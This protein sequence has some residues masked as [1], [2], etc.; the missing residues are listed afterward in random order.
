MR[1]EGAGS[2]KSMIDRKA[3]ID[4][5]SDWFANPYDERKAA[6]VVAELQMSI[7]QFYRLKKELKDEIN[8]AAD[9]KRAKY[10]AEIRSEAY[11]ALVKRFSRSDRAIELALKVMGDLVE[12]SEVNNTYMT[13]EQKREKASELIARLS[14]KLTPTLPSNASP[15]SSLSEIEGIQNNQS[16]KENESQNKNGDG[17]ASDIAGV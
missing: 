2:F 15:S 3:F 11:K 16:E 1:P 13:P 8:L 7:S 12:R 5:T 10:H 4:I 14:A 6:D 17:A 9:K